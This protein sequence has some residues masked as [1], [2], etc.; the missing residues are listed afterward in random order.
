MR[1]L[2]AVLCGMVLSL[3]AFCAEGPIPND[4]ASVRIK[5]VAEILGVRENQLV[6]QGLM[7]GLEGTGDKTGDLTNQALANFIARMFF[8]TTQITVPSK[9]PPSLFNL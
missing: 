9:K 2:I 5:D 1:V 4:V 3:H 8:Q 6:G 7:V